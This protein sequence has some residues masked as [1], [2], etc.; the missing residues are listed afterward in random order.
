ME[1][2]V[3][4]P[5]ICIRRNFTVLKKCLRSETVGNIQEFVDELEVGKDLVFDKEV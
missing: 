3:A 5:L 1:N 2:R 4:L